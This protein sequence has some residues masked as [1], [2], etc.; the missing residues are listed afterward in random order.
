MQPD[1]SD[2]FRRLGTALAQQQKWR[3]AVDAYDSAVR[4]D[5]KTLDLKY[6]LALACF[7]TREPEPFRIAAEL[8]LA[9]AEKSEQDSD[10]ATAAWLLALRRPDSV[11]TDQVLTLARRAVDKKPATWSYR[12]T[13]AA[14]LYRADDYAAV[15]VEL[16]KALELWEKE[17][18]APIS[19]DDPNA[20]DPK[21]AV[22]PQPAKPAEGTV[23]TQ[24]FLALAHHA[25][26]HAAEATHH[27]EIAARL[28]TE[29]PNTEWQE[30]LRRELLLQDLSEVLGPESPTPTSDTKE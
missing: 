23:W 16:E 15:I 8:L 5:A 27:R 30:R 1:K 29:S 7:A 2:V 14:I 28:V 13:L 4:L 6:E 3:D 21:D 12:E 17:N 18:S 24:T 11:A 9:S 19:S 22:D 20:S 26:G 10:W 25:L